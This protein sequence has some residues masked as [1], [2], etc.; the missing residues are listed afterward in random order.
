MEALHQHIL[1][2][3]SGQAPGYLIEPQA[4]SF[5][6]IGLDDPAEIDKALHALQDE[7]LVEYI[8]VETDF[9]VEN[10]LENEDG[11]YELVKSV[12]TNETDWGWALTEKGKK[13]IE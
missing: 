7:G 11:T 4:A 2:I 8:T 9:E 6:A 10:Y 13:A 12:L 5:M 3:M 1:H